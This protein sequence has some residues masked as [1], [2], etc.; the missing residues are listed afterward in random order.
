[1]NQSE[2]IEALASALNNVQREELFA[3]T[4][5]ENPFFKSKYADLSSV[6]SVARKPLTDNGLSVV[7][8]MRVGERDNPIIVTTLLHKSG[9]WI[10]GEL[11]MP[12]PKKDPQQFGSAVTYGRRYSLAA[13][14]GVCPADDDGQSATNGM[15]KE[16]PKTQAPKSNGD[17]KP[18]S[19]AQHKK[20]YA[21]MIEKGFQDTDVDL[22]RDFLKSKYKLGPDD[23][24]TSKHLSQVFDNFERCCESFLEWEKTFNKKPEPGDDIPF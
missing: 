20:L 10:R 22:M 24:L 23:K 14:L 2:K 19:Q 17:P 1:M 11:E 9:Q 7:Q 3:L 4:D 18:A 15:K 16:K 5:K 13:L 8:T 6:W 12:A 21:M